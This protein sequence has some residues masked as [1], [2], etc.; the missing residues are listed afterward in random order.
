VFTW[1]EFKRKFREANVPESVMALKRREFENIE[2][3]DK[4][5]MRY[6]REFSGLSRYA[7]DE[8]STEYKSKKRFMGRLNLSFKMQPRMLK[9]TKFQ[10]LVYATI[11]MEDDF[12]QV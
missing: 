8:V 10:E 3:K 2:Q 9:T 4:S 7:A 6:V 11:I 5:I 12:K 1:E